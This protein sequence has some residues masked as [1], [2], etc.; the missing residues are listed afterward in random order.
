RIEQAQKQVVQAQ[1]ALTFAQEESDR[2]QK[3]A[4]TAA[5]T[6]QQ[7]QQARSNLLQGQ[8]SLAA[9]QANAVTT[10]E[11]V[12]V[13]QTQRRGAE[14]QLAQAQ[15]QLRQADANLSRT[16][17]T[18]PVEGRVTKLS[19]AK[20]AYAQVGQSLLMFVPSEIWVTANF[21]ETQLAHMQP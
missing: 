8:A 3:L 1:A 13:L 15:A 2:Y 6:V 14:G 12:P 4:Q 16:E 20:G 21:K 5:G 9:A 7:A 18:A 10:E 11:Q 19:A 17:I